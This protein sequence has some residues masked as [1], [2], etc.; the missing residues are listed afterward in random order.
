MHFLFRA[1]VAVAGGPLR[2]EAPAIA[3]ASLPAMLLATAAALAILRY[4]LSPIAVL[5]MCAA[6]GLVL[7]FAGIGAIDA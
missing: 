6:T 3:S 1:T 5:A 2:F 7:Q 4:R